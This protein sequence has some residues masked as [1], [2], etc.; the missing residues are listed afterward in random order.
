M[1][2]KIRKLV[3]SVAVDYLRSK[4]AD[5][6]AIDA[7]I[8]IPRVDKFG[9]YSTNIALQLAKP[10]KKSPKNIAE[11]ITVLLLARD[12]GR[13][14]SSVESVPKG[15]INFRI[16]DLF[17]QDNLRRTVKDDKKYGYST[18]GNGE[19]ILLEYVSANPTGPLHVGHGRW[20]VIGSSIAG[21]LNAAGFKVDSEFYINDIGNQIDLLIKS[22]EARIS[23]RPLPEGGY[24]GQ[25]IKLLADDFRGKK[26]E[27]AAVLGLILERQKKVL[28]ELKVHFGKWFKESDLHKDKKIAGTV[29]LLEERGV[30]FFDKGAKWFRSTDFGDDKDRVLEREGGA[31]TYFASDVAY[32]LDKFKRKYDHLINVWG[33]DHHGYVARLKGAMEVLGFPKEKLEIIIGQLVILFRGKEQVRMSKRTGEMITLKEVMDEIGVDATRYFLVRTSP[34]THLNFD[35]ELAKSKS[36]E[37]PV[38]YVQYAHARISSILREALKQGLKPAKSAD[39]KLLTDPSERKLLVKI[40]KYPDEVADA[41]LFRQPHKLTIFAEDLA[42]VFHNFYHNCRVISDDKKLSSARLTLV[43]AARIV[44]R[45]VLELLGVN[46]PESM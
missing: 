10:L 3:E 24:G 22:I 14:F 27:A 31:S 26:V 25:Y 34:N 7:S 17:L 35:L 45:N 9:E 6:K 16:T 29:K 28:E 23:D 12:N 21:I 2:E 30:T 11:D 13:Y 40:L 15:F 37:N 39:L 5:E 20:A 41:A 4:N 43:D 36:Q 1:K 8:E 33:T 18:V 32:H 44:I 46:A 42:T 38:Y 19:K